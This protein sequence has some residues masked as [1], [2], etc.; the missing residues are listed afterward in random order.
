VCHTNMA[1]DKD[2]ANSDSW[3][4]ARAAVMS[5][6]SVAS[7]FITLVRLA[8]SLAGCQLCSA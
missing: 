3:H 4:K 8:S 5:P 6:V 2:V 1:K 7:S